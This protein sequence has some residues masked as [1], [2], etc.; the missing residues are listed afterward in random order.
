MTLARRD[1]LA[2]QEALKNAI[3]D[4]DGIEY[5]DLKLPSSI[6]K[7]DDSFLLYETNYEK[8]RFRSSRYYLVLVSMLLVH[9]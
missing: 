1:E 8:H 3:K 9:H 4:I 5:D 2:H 7:T 6:T